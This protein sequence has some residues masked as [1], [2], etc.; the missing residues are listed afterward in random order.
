MPENN[1]EISLK[2]LVIKIR[3]WIN[4]LLNKW[5]LLVI[6]GIIG[7]ALGFAYA[8]SSKPKYEAKTTFVLSSDNKTS[9]LM[10]L[11][12]QFGVDMG[13]G[14]NDAFS[15]ENI[16]TLFKSRLLVQRA[17]F[18]KLPE[19]NDLLINHY[20][21]VHGLD[22]AWDTKERTKHAYPF[23]PNV[24]LTPVQDSL[25][26]EIHQAIVNAYLEVAKPDKKT[27]FY[28]VKTTSN[29]EKFSLYL[30]RYLVNETTSF[31]IETKTRLARQN[32]AMLHREADSLRGLLNGTITAAAVAVD[33]TFGLNP[34]YSSLRTA[35]VQTG[36]VRTTVLATAYGEIVKNLEIA[37]ITLQKETPLFQI[38]DE[39]GLPLKVQKKSEFLSAIIG[40]IIL[41]II[42]I[43]TLILKNVF[44]TIKRI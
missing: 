7:G 16:I 28:E 23:P 2:E 19:N 8:Y 21:K 4:Y 9:G 40:S 24:N 38:I 33:R 42:F 44:N 39:A 25:I 14:G 20:C 5:Y 36:Q 26:R 32:L 11:A 35:P 1:D 37:K 10:G 18:K 13:G 31:Y 30:T 17:L 22:K 27:S 29:D 3:G 12:S 15:G 43:V 34:A 6:A 41:S